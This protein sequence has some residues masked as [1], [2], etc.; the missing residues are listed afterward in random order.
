MR[1]LAGPSPSGPRHCSMGYRQA[2]KELWMHSLQTQALQTDISNSENQSNSE[3]IAR[4]F[5]ANEFGA[6][7]EIILLDSV[8]LTEDAARQIVDYHIPDIDGLKLAIVV[9]RLFSKRRL[10][11]T[12]IQFMRKLLKCRANLFYNSLGISREHY[13]RI[14]NNMVSIPTSTEKLLRIFVLRN[15]L[16]FS[17]YNSNTKWHIMNNNFVNQFNGDSFISD[18]SNNELTIRLRRD[19]ND[20][21]AITQSDRRSDLRWLGD[22]MR[23]V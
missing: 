17:N 7:F 1:W 4:I 11:G 15:A 23:P 21:F 13:S 2:Q 10:S 19:M 8:I 3:T 12:D 20:S 16:D 22:V 9:E 18:D 6:P 14:E 5:Y